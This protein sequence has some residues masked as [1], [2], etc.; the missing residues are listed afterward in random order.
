MSTAERTSADEPP[1]SLRSLCFHAR[2]PDD[3]G[4]PLDVGLDDLRELLGRN[5]IDFVAERRELL[6]DVRSA[7][8][9][10]DLVAQLRDDLARRTR[11]C[12]QPGPSRELQR[13][14]LFLERRHL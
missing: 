3:V 5:A 6:A 7:Q 9:L 1:L 10:D 2:L 11:R 13:D 8:R 4:H 14:A 12:E